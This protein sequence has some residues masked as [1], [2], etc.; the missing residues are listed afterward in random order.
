MKRISQNFRIV[1]QA[2][3]KIYTI[4]HLLSFLP[5]PKEQLVDL[6]AVVSSV[7]RSREMWHG[8][9]GKIRDAAASKFSVWG[10]VLMMLRHVKTC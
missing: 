7:L 1:F 10:Y 2:F 4:L 8:A 5:K 9:I 6:L 3:S